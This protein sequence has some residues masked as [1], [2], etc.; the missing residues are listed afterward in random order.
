[1]IKY[2]FIA[3]LSLLF[4]CKSGS[5]NTDVVNETKTDSLTPP[6]ADTIGT[7]NVKP[8][9]IGKIDIE[10]FGDIKIGQPHVKTIAAIGQPDKKSKPEEWGADGLMHQD[11]TYSSKGLVLNISFA[12]E[13]VDTTGYVSSITANSTA[14][15]KTRANMGIGNTYTEVMEAYKRDIDT[16]ATTKEQLTV[17]SIY[18][19]IIFTFKNDKVVKIFLGAVAE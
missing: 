13:S 18:G 4:S 16:E 5:K 15:F 10:T 14:S 6:I 19:G 1:M 17:G 9:A 3:A 11:W 2:F 12:K 7:N 8:P